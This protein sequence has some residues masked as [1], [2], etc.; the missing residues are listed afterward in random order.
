MRLF[1]TA[2]AA[3]LITTSA[4]ASETKEELARELIE[5]T[6]LSQV[7]LEASVDS[8]VNGVVDQFKLMNKPLTA[9][10]Q[11]TLE[12]ASFAAVEPQMKNFV[13]GVEK[14]YTET[15]TVEELK[16]SIAYH[17]TPEGLSA[18]HKTVRMAPQMMQLSMKT[19]AGPLQK[20]GQ[21]EISKIVMEQV[22][23][24]KAK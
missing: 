24:Q 13:A 16:A 22:E 21:E 17:K 3:T 20:V 15:Y 14:L 10:Q 6:D 5:I 19:L 18:Y 7:T 1:V 23:A 8:F 12:K 2:L 4:M 11:E 9:E